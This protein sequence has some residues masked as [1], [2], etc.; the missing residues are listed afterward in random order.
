MRRATLVH[1]ILSFVFNVAVL[2]L[3]VNILVSVI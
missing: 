2:A 1:S 3:S